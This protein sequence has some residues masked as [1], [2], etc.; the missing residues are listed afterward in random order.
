M[1][2]TLHITKKKDWTDKTPIITQEE[3]D[4]LISDGRLEKITDPT[5]IAWDA[6]KEDVYF[7]FYNGDI[8]S[9]PRKEED[10]EKIKE[11]AKTL[12][13]TKVQGDD[14]ELYE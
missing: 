5:M 4:S 2:Y 11:I 1:A 7:S 12:P 13:N 8:I 9:N 14:G 10:I 6:K 3:W